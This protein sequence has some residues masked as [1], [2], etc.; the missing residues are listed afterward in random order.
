MPKQ[1]KDLTDRL[2]QKL[3]SEDKSQFE[4]FD[5]QVSGLLLRV[6]SNGSKTWGFKFK[7]PVDGK[8]GC[9]IY[10]GPYGCPTNPTISLAM[11]REKARDA[12]RLIAEGKDPRLAPVAQTVRTVSDLIDDRIARRLRHSSKRYIRTCLEVERVYDRDVI[13]YVG[14]VPISEFTIKHMNDILRPI[15]DRGA[16]TLA[17][18]ATLHMKALFNFAVEEGELPYNPI[19]K[20]RAPKKDGDGDNEDDGGR[21]LSPDEVAAVWHL[22]PNVF[23]GSKYAAMILRIQLATGQRI[24]EVA[25]MRKSELDLRANRPFW[26]I[27]PDRV[28]NKK[29]KHVVPLNAV[30]L[31]LIRDAV[32]DASGDILFENQHGEPVKN[33]VIIR[34]LARAHEKKNGLPLGR[35][36]MEAWTTHS[37]RRTVSDLPSRSDLGMPVADRYMDHILNHRSSTKNTVRKRHY[38]P[39]DYF[40]EKADALDE[41]GTFLARIIGNDDNMKIAAE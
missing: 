41:W 12:Q 20:F 24:S 27:S 11:A 3:T 37:L 29:G 14:S 26:T 22:L 36:N 8:H 25:G 33:R 13:P 30:A 40:D 31:E 35:F 19:A 38:N 32:R 34:A 5:G 21:S 16:M 2:I 1:S 17:L 28:K 18:H 9:R 4:H 7:N 10:I 6:T 39:H 23:A 15:V